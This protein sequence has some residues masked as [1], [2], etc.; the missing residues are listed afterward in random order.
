[1]NAYADLMTLL[2]GLGAI[3][4]AASLIGY[5]LQ[6]LMSPD[7][8]NT[9]IENLND[10][11]QVAVVAVLGDPC[12]ARDTQQFDPRGIFDETCAAARNDDLFPCGMRIHV[13]PPSARLAFGVGITPRR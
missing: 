8:S 2:G 4:V 9:V 10:R 5:V 3:L 12:S 6:R 11:I 13:P 1:M 7:G